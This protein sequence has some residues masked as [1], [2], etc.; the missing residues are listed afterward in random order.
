MKTVDD[1]RAMQQA[2]ITPAIASEVLGCNQHWLR[3]MARE[4]P[5]QLGFPVCCM[6]SRVKIPRLAFIR[7]LTGE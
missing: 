6:G 7:F 4:R 2:M 1:L 3:L 5:E